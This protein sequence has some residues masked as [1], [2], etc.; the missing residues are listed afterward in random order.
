ME[1]IKIEDYQAMIN[2]IAWSKSRQLGIEFEEVV[3]RGTVLFYEILPTF[4]PS[5]SCFSTYF[6]TKLNGYLIRTYD[7]DN[8]FLS[9]DQENAD[10]EGGTLHDVVAGN[11]SDP[12][13][14][15]EFA[16]VLQDLSNEAKEV[17]SIIFSCPQEIVDGAQ[18]SG[19]K[20]CGNLRKILVNRGMKAYKIARAFT[21]I[22]STLF[23]N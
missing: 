2:K 6:Y 8:M 15:Y 11:S 4:D 13:Q 23:S 22:R 9:L 14:V 16:S 12:A 1:K 17:I 18:G 5:K 19:W 3:G 21:E 10:S 7:K 20:M